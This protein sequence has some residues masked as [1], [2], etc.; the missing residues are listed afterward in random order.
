MMENREKVMSKVKE[1]T[2]G[3]SVIENEIQIIYDFTTK[4]LKEFGTFIKTVAV[5]GSFVRH[6]LE[7]KSDIDIMILVDDASVTLTPQ[8]M[9]YYE[10]ELSKLLAK[11]GSPLKFHVNTLTLS[12]FWDGIR[13]GDPVIINIVRD[14]VPIADAGFFA[15]VKLLLEKGKIRPT[16][17]AVDFTMSR[18]YLH[19][20]Q[21]NR[22]M[23]DAANE[24]YWAVTDAG[25]AAL[26]KEGLVP[27]TP[28]D[29]AIMLKD[30]LVKKGKMDAKDIKLVND[31]YD[32]MKKITHGEINMVKG[33]HLDKLDGEVK[34]YLDKVRRIIVYKE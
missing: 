34:K 8:V 11:E 14:G 5:Y 24:L 17:E 30:K 22:L 32:L 20:I 29:V 13:M 25:H 21:F 19:L 2:I 7:Y 28:R 10:K 3:S 27:P 18:A 1:G 12:E 15:P 9:D 6:Q 23:M 33:D 16:D 31:L 26:M 4:V